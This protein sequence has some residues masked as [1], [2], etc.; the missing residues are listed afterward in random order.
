M[1][2]IAEKLEKLETDYSQLKCLITTLT[3]AMK[4]CEYESLNTIDLLYLQEYI[5]VKS[6]LLDEKLE[7]LTDEI[8]KKAAIELSKQ[9]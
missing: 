3:Y 7:E 8:Y 4:Y 6:K 5:N 2:D 9:N 1:K